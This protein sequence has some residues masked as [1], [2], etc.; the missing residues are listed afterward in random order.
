MRSRDAV[1]FDWA[2]TQEN[3]AIVSKAL[4]ERGSASERARHLA[5]ASGYIDAA[6]E[7]FRTEGDTFYQEKATRLATEI[8]QSVLDND[9]GRIRVEE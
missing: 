1:P 8:R 6:L 4:A 3:L 2:L 9:V 5:S 7:F